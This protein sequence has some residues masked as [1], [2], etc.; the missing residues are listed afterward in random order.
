VQYVRPQITTREPIAGLLA[1]GSNVKQP[2]GAQ[3]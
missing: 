1:A 3:P 2:D